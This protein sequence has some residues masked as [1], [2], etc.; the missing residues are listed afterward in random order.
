MAASCMQGRLLSGWSW[1]R[2]PPGTP[3]LIASVGRHAIRSGCR[4][5]LLQ[6]QA[7]SA[8][9]T[10]EPLATVL[11]HW[12]TPGVPAG[13]LPSLD[14]TLLPH[15][16]MGECGIDHDG[17]PPG[18]RFKYDNHGVAPSSLSLETGQ[19]TRLRHEVAREIEDH[20][21]RGPWDRDIG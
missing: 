20:L 19:A 4:H 10:D 12:A 7:S 8:G 18:H 16:P 2:F 1:V 14:P 15:S 11:C 13:S 17:A 3:N 6:W 21:R 5:G 9:S